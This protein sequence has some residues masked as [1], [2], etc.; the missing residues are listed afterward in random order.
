M[1]AKILEF[2]KP[3]NKSSNREAGQ[4]AAVTR[5]KSNHEL[6]MEAYEDVI[7]DW[8]RFATN[9]RLSEYVASK[10]P[11]SAVNP[12][13]T[14][15]VNDLNVIAGVEQKLN[16]KVAVFY[17]E[18]T[19]GQHGWMATLHLGKEIFS[20]PADMASEANARALLIVLS[21]HFKAVL[22]SLGRDIS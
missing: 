16:M 1:T 17:P 22:K 6:F 14:D 10:L 11:P 5:L 3:E 4:K 13:I 21:L 12:L 8:Q 15:Y 2:K 18:C 9:N 7:G 20:T 19:P